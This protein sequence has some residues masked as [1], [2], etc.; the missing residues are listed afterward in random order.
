[1]SEYGTVK[2]RDILGTLDGKFRVI[3]ETPDEQLHDF[4]VPF[5]VKH[6]PDRFYVEFDFESVRHEYGPSHEPTTEIISCPELIE[7]EAR[8]MKTKILQGANV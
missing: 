3:T 1:M 4:F 8:D 2:H 7:N 6:G 5:N